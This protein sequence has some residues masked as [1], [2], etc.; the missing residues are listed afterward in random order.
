MLKNAERILSNCRLLPPGST[1][2]CALSGGADSMCLAHLLS[3]RPG[4]TLHAAH[5]DHCLRGAESE[6]DARFVQRWCQEHHIPLH[7]GRGDVAAQAKA[8]GTGIEETARQMRYAFLRETAGHIGAQIIAT[9]HNADD[10]AETILLHLIRG[11]GLSGLC[12]I[13]PRRGDLIRPLITTSRAEI[14][15]YLDHYQI[16]HREDSSNLDPTYARNRLR[17]QVM[18]VLQALNPQAAAHMG[19]TAAELAS[20]DGWLDQQVQPYLSQIQT[21]PGRVSV[22]VCTLS[23]APQPLQPRILLGLLD[24]LRVGRKDFGAIH[25]QALLELREGGQLN[26][27]QGVTACRKVPVKSRRSSRWKASWMAAGA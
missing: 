14:L 12:G 6:E 13:P 17:T 22:P 7:L 11:T 8:L 21:G 4:L 10:N 18:P 15:A 24:T 26:L 27:P 23:S 5:F 3:R 9:A 1:V 25:L 19:R 2:L 16:P 20:L